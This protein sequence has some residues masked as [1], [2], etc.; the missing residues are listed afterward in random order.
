M[1]RDW[2]FEENKF[3][4]EVYAVIK[5]GTKEERKAIYDKIVRNYSKK[6]NLIVRKGLIYF[7]PKTKGK[8]IVLK[9]QRLYLK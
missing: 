2:I 6:Y 3:F 9:E 7:E 1:D 5:P 8:I 4:G